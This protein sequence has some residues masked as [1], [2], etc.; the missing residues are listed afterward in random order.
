M[1]DLEI[2]LKALDGD[3]ELLQDCLLILSQDLPRRIDAL[4][5]A[6]V[7]G[8]L[9]AAGNLAHTIKGSVA[10]VGARAL[11]NDALAVEAAVGESRLTLATEGLRNLQRHWTELQ[12]F[13]Q[14]EGLL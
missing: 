6:L 13:L 7:A 2:A 11:K 3:R 8:D 5:S 9:A 14:E 1:I 10:V 4:E 12:A